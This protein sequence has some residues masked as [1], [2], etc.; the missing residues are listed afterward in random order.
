MSVL[1]I[2][3]WC[4]LGMGVLAL[5]CEESTANLD[6]AGADG[7][8]DADAD[9]DTDTDGDTDSD[10]D[11]DTDTDTDA[12]TDSD[13]DSD[14]DGDPIVIDFTIDSSADV[15]AISPYI[16]G[17]NQ[18]DWS[19]YSRY[20]T[21]G[22]AGGNRWTAYNWETN[23]SN[24]GSDWNYSN[25]GYLEG[26]DTPGEAV[27]FRTRAA[28]DANA[29][30]L[31]TVPICGHVSADKNGNVDL[32]DPNHLN[33]RFHVSQAVK[34]SPFV[35][36][37]DLND[38]FVYQDEFVNW[39]GTTF[40]DAATDPMRTIFYSLDNEPDLWAGTHREIHPDPVTYVELVGKTIDFATAIKAVDS[41]A[42]IFGFVSYGWYGYTTLQNAPDSG[43]Y[44]DFINYF[45]DQLNQADSDSGQR[46]VDVLDL[47]WYP[48][49]EANGVRI[50][51]DNNSPAVVEARLQA[52]RSLWDSSYQ[53]T[54]WIVDSIP[55][56]IY[57]LPRLRQK[58]E[59]HYPGT[60]IAITEYQYGGYGHISGGLAQ[61]DVLGIFGRENIFAANLWHLNGSH[62]FHYGAFAMYRNYDGAG[63]AFGD[64]SISA[65][66]TDHQA[67]SIYASVDAG[68][69]NRL[70]IVALNKTDRTIEGRFGVEH[71]VSF[72]SAEA[73]ALTA[74]SADPVQVSSASLTNNQFTYDL[75]PMS[76]HT[77]VLTP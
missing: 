30:M 8:S 32:S 49:A 35:L 38:D 60:K 12:D 45:L 21:F 55:G 27:R 67:S 36:S 26:G 1:R 33:D 46:L 74:A 41:S 75:P 62:S 68:N 37:P 16:Y 17:T 29:S 51:E 7:D 76:V 3:I 71:S 47:H 5:A 70:V 43:T 22:R 11:T 42:T 18:P 72:S 58:I 13:A 57:L 34:G 59:E 66:T 9:T 24:A 28:L 65:G 56:P 19:T 40:P 64:T 54:S 61:A 48:E 50:I 73:F 52:P 31:I 10:T 39:V 6:D 69:D 14:S 20:L 4:A 2:F 63:G 44:G 53:E 77:F 25:D 15:H 23:A